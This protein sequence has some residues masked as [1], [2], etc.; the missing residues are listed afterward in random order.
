M[1]KKLI[2]KVI[3]KIRANKKN[4]YKNVSSTARIGSNVRVVSP[5]YLIMGENSRLG[6]NAVIMNGRLGQFV[7][8]K[9]SGIATDL[10]AICGN[11]MPVV[12]IPHVK[13]D[14]TMKN[15]LESR[16]LRDEE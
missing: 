6:N 10:F 8:K 1:L 2:K 4:I 13:V 12:G 15:K 9:N 7:I 14:E 5:D 11:H 16:V 3:F